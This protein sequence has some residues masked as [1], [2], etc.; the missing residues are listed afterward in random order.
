MRVHGD[1]GAAV[2]TE[3]MLSFLPA[4]VVAFDRVLAFQVNHIRTRRVHVHVAIAR[5]DTTVAGLDLM[6][7]Q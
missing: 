2:G 7:V 5:A 1:A 4:K 3:L 6:L